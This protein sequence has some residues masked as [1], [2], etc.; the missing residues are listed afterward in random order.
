[1]FLAFFL[2]LCIIDTQAFIDIHPC[3]SYK[4]AT[5][6]S[7]CKPDQIFIPIVGYDTSLIKWAPRH[8]SILHCPFSWLSLLISY[9]IRKKR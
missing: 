4:Y 3:I 7:I 2:F 9:K 1:M 6:Y 5:K 8:F